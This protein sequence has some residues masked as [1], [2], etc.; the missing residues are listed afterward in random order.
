MGRLLDITWELGICYLGV[1]KSATLAEAAQENGWNIRRCGHRRYPHLC[2]TL[3]E[4]PRPVAIAG[5]DIAL[6]RHEED[7]FKPYFSPT[8]TWDYLRVKKTKLPWHCIVWFPQANPRQAFMVWLVFKDKLSTGITIRMREWGTQKGC[9]YCRKKDESR[10][11]LFFACQYTLTVWMNVA[12]KLLGAV[13]TPDWEDTI[14]S[15]QRPNRNILD[16]ILLRLV[17]QTDIYVLWKERNSRRHGGVCAS[18]DTTTKVIGRLIKNRI[19]S[20]KYRENH[21]LRGLLVKWF[22]VYTY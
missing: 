16:T 21:K 19:S 20:V 14:A 1:S 3:A 13:T 12:E 15:L 18:V 6:W 7:D 5:P 9:V 22:I 4:A 17:F 2:D 10:D 11:D 8:K